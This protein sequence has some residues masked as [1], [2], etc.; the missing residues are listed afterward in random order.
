MGAPAAPEGVLQR[1]HALMQR[2]W[3]IGY[4]EGD[5]ATA[6]AF[7]AD[8][9]TEFEAFERWIEPQL[10]PG[11]PL[12]RMAGWGNK[13]NGACARLAA[14]LHVADAL[15][16]GDEWNRPIGAD[17]VRR[18]VRLCRD[19]YIPHG[20]AAF[21]LVGANLTLAGARR[22]WAWVREKKLTAFS[23]RDALN[24]NR[25]IETVDDLQPC[26]D[27][28]ERHYLIRQQGASET[29][30]RGRPSSP[31]YD[32]NP[33]PSDQD[34]RPDPTPPPSPSGPQDVPPE[35][36]PAAECT[37]AH[38][39]QNTQ[40]CRPAPAPPISADIADS[41]RGCAPAAPPVTTTASGVATIAEALVGWE[42]PVGLDTETTGLNPL[43]DRVRLIQVA[44]GDEVAVIDVFALPD[45][46]ADLEPLFAVLAR[47]EVVGHN[48][49]FDLAFLAKLGF[50]PGRTRDTMLAS[51]VLDAGDR[52]VRHGLKDVA[53]RHLG[54][55]VDKELQ[56]ADWSGRLTPDML[57]YAAR[58]AQHP[59]RL[60]DKL[61][62]AAA[63][64]GLT[65][66]LADESAALP[67]VA[68]ATASGIGFDRAAWERLAAEAEAEVVRLADALDAAAPS[69]HT[70]TAS[71]NWNSPEQ[72]VA[73][74]A[75]HGVAL[76]SSDDNAL[77]AVDHPAADLL[78]EYRSAA[79]L[80]DA[81][82][83][84][85]LRHVAADGRV[86]A[87]WK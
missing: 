72:A 48:L 15:G 85:W 61:E 23:K 26:L 12:A 13:P 76:T 10:A 42:Q 9:L 38:N 73:T 7:D 18:A 14:A 78:R 52:T 19:Y 46:A 63:A 77:A 25:T 34:E 80:A 75:A 5:T 20:V 64:A 3:K 71:T 51:Q 22:V 24:G 6:L 43:T 67:C 58:D 70:L 81:Y 53:A 35:S 65:G 69:P 21:D 33:G 37:P 57:F 29:R 32:V 41:A 74:F 2:A 4:G 8:A 54:L 31:M 86:Y 84:E 50:V 47:K 82:G 11:R 56:A 30:G 79:K 66:V 68:W 28:L 1:Y 27:L 87:T 36:A 49:S 40:K 39:S 45:P 44:V 83:R 59:L 16:A 17:V 60:W 62:S 55:E